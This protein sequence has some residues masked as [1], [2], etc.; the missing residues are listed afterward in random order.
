MRLLSG[1]RPKPFSSRIPNSWP[2]I[3]HQSHSSN[4]SQS[5]KNPPKNPTKNTTHPQSHHSHGTPQP[6]P[7]QAPGTTVSSAGASAP[8]RTLREFILNSP[9]GRLGR[10]YSRIQQRRPYRTQL[11]SSVVIYLCGDL[12]AQLWFPSSSESGYDPWRTAKHLTVGAGASIPSYSWYVAISHG[13]RI[14][15]VV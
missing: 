7:S 13:Y 11:C 8:A 1:P 12:S 15:S 5:P 3:R 4:P 14:Q 10:T 2:R 6:Q 9:L